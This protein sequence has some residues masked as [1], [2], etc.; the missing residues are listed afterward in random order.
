VTRRPLLALLGA[1]ALVG[2]VWTLILPAS[3]GP[4]EISHFAYTQTMAERF[5][6]PNDSARQSES[7]EQALAGDLSN[8]ERT[9]GFLDVKVE[10]SPRVYKRWRELDRALPDSARSDGGAPNPASPNPPG[11]YLYA[12]LPYRVAYGGD[13]FD[14]YY[15]TRLASALLLL[16][17][18]AIT[19]V[20]AGELLGPDRR[21]QLV[22]A[23]V[24]GLQPMGTFV[25]ATVGPDALVFPLWALVMWLGVRA[26]RR[27]L[28]LARAAALFGV[29]GLAVAV[30]GVSYTLVPAV[31]FV[32]AVGLWR[33][34]ADSP[35][36]AVALAGAAVLAF[37]A[38]GGGWIA[39][40]LVLDRP[41]L[42]QTGAV[43]LA[44][45]EF[46]SYVW[47]FYLPRLPFQDRNPGIG[48][49][50]LSDLGV[51]A[52]WLKT[53]WG[54]FG[55]LEIRFPEWVYAVLAALSASVLVAGV[56]AL[57]RSRAGVTGAAIVFLALLAGGLVAGLHWTEYK[58]IVD[59]GRGSSQGRYLLPLLPIA[60]LLTASALGWLRPSVRGLAAGL[61]LSG[62]F[63]LQ[64][65]SLAIVAWRFY[66]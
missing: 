26:L 3:Q 16:A 32:L 31:L 23:A 19:W 43:D 49:D 20:L 37:A 65:F 14:R 41:L 42:D 36:R 15:L 24:A 34:R 29:A 58:I 48:A 46:L 2:V 28:T 30:K 51:Y 64:L 18:T 47:Q 52:V 56:S 54:A 61:V 5:R 35:R 27:G 57:V 45:R 1:V 10:W 6:L 53:G 4:D 59:S 21:L 7:T 17:T 9:P 62:L 55:S 25:S 63:S 40:A 12:A 39:T 50:S 13:I 22:A 33:L 11:Y 60:G 38:L 66:A 44:L 8:I